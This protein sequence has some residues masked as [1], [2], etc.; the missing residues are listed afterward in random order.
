V[1]PGGGTPTLP[2]EARPVR[3][4][5]AVERAQANRLWFDAKRG[6]W[7]PAGSP[8]NIWPVHGRFLSLMEPG[9]RR[10]DSCPGLAIP[11]RERRRFL[12]GIG[13]VLARARRTG[14]PA[15]RPPELHRR[16][17]RPRRSVKTG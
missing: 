3:G 11:P 10:L 1:Y 13:G 7:P 12:F 16:E 14:E 2:I 17:R 9:A 8:R 15:P 4:P 6:E 5:F